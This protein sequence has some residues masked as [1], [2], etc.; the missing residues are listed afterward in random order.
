MA[1]EYNYGDY[2]TSRTGH[3]NNKPNTNKEKNPTTGKKHPNSIHTKSDTRKGADKLG[4]TKGNNPVSWLTKLLT[5]STGEKPI[6]NTKTAQEQ[7]KHNDS[8]YT[9]YD[10]THY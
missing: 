6:K 8:N 2:D 3:T 4:M 7:P 10:K 5:P 9:E 1:H